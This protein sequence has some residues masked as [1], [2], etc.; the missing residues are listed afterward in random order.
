M[1]NEPSLDGLIALVNA[2]RYP[3]IIRSVADQIKQAIKDEIGP[4]LLIGTLIEGTVCTLA[5]NI[6]DEK[7]HELATCTLLLMTNRLN[8]LGL[9]GKS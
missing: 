5:A 7:H 3:D 4:Y 1:D 9:L 2:T 6:P 8:A